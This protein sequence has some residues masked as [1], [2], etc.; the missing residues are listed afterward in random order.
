MTKLIISAISSVD[1]NDNGHFIFFVTTTKRNKNK[2]Y[3]TKSSFSINNSTKFSNL[4]LMV[5]VKVVVVFFYDSTQN[6]RKDKK[7]KH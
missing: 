3:Q 6:F 5:M 7:C 1:V 2:C 4:I